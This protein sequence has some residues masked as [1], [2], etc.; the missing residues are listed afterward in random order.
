MFNNF[1]KI[2]SC[3]RNRFNLK[4]QKTIEVLR[5]VKREHLIVDSP[6]LG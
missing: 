3:T 1:V 4:V 2:R 6:V 5:I